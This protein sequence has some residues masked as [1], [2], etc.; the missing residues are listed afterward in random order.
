MSGMEWWFFVFFPPEKEMYRRDDKIHL[1]CTYFRLLSSSSNAVKSVNAKLAHVSLIVGRGKGRDQLITC[2]HL[3]TC[4]L[5]P[6]SA[7]T[8]WWCFTIGN[9]S[10]CP[11]VKSSATKAWSRVRGTGSQDC[12][13]TLVPECSQIFSGA[14]TSFTVLE[15][16]LLLA[17]AIGMD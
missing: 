3:A 12:G 10:N 7:L 15:E 5:L 13:N 14:Y 8:E 17:A 6:V 11:A 1:C 9:M 16:T 2:K 4:L